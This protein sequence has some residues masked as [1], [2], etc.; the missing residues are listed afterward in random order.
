MAHPIDGISLRYHFDVVITEWVHSV[1]S[2]LVEHQLVDSV[3]DLFKKKDIRRYLEQNLY[4][5]SIDVVRAL[6]RRDFAK[7]YLKQDEMLDVTCPYDILPIFDK[8]WTKQGNYK[9]KASYAWV[10]IRKIVY[11]WRKIKQRIYATFKTRKNRSEVNDKGAIAVEL[12]EGANPSTKSDVY[13]LSSGLIDAKKVILL[14]E[15]RNQYFLDIDKQIEEAHKSGIYNLIALDPEMERA[16][17]INYWHP[18]KTPDWVGQFKK[19]IT[20]HKKKKVDRWLQSKLITLLD[21]VGYWEVFFNDNGV[22]AYQHF[23]ELSRDTIPRQI[24]IDRTGG[25]EFGRQR[26][27]YLWPASAA[28]YFLHEVAFCWQKSIGAIMESGY[29]SPDILIQSGYVYEDIIQSEIGKGSDIRKQLEYNNVK[30]VIAAFDNAPNINNNNHLSWEYLQNFYKSIREI[31]E[32]YSEVG[33]IIKTKKPQIPAHPSLAPYFSYFSSHDRCIVQKEQLSSIMPAALAADIAIGIPVSTAL[34]EAA[35]TNIPVI[36]YDP[37]NTPINPFEQ[38]E[39]DFVLP[40]I[41]C[42]QDC[43]QK[44]IDKYLLGESIHSRKV[45]Y[46]DPYQD[47][48][49]TRRIAT[50]I[51][52][53]IMRRENGYGKQESITFAK[54]ILDTNTLFD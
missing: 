9:I 36:A 7:I 10:L 25:I 32:K 30:I 18:D 26:S 52:E 23:S 33:F 54:N 17:M 22:S 38:S 35:L 37:M 53:F 3:G 24:A 51:R 45:P 11:K 47:G 49:A 19:E 29:G 46:I 15:N 13:W 31:L 34:T 6:Y 41:D 40:S 28:N 2:E 39:G 4:I 27:Q 1:C 42:F 21:R 50:F 5:E 48:S 16:G 43:L 12:V 14:F 44:L 8:Y 20:A